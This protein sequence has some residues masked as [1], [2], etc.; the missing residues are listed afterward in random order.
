MA[1]RFAAA[2]SSDHRIFKTAVL[3]SE[4]G[5]AVFFCISVG[6]WRRRDFFA[7]IHEL[8]FAG[9]RPA[10]CIDFWF[11]IN[12]TLS[13]RLNARA[14]VC[15][16]GYAPNIKKGLDCSRPVCRFSYWRL[17]LELPVRHR[18]FE[19]VGRCNRCRPCRGKCGFIDLRLAQV[20]CAVCACDHH[21]I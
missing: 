15:R 4:T 5:A 3:V 10:A 11:A 13:G 21:A 16:A 18:P 20:R 1:K 19:L 8:A 17:G 12:S 2:N 9:G 6:W 14:K 7:V